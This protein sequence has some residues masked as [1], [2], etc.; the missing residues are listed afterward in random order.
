MEDIKKIV[1]EYQSLNLHAVIDYDKFNQ[2]AIVHHSSSIEGSTLTE[3]ETRL[4]LE[5]GIT[6][7]G[8]PLER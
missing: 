5:E 1:D 4:L 7:K 3:N 6:P 2:Y 8:K